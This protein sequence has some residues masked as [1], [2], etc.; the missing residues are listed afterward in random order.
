MYRFDHLPTHS[1]PGFFA[2]LSKQY[3]DLSGENEAAA[4][5]HVT[6]QPQLHVHL[7]GESFG[8]VLKDIVGGALKVV[9][10]VGGGIATKVLGGL[11]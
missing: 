7:V 5:V 2:D 4:D 9:T 10:D 8:H 11:L 6:N 1:V 3:G